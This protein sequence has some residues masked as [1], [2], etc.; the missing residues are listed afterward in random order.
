[1]IGVIRWA[2]RRNQREVVVIFP[3][4]GSIVWRSQDNSLSMFYYYFFR[5][6]CCIGTHSALHSQ[7]RNRHREAARKS[8]TKWLA[9]RHDGRC[10]SAIL[11]DVQSNKQGQNGSM[12]VQ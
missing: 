7:C 1:M 12:M 4:G 2:F 6:A 11:V 10:G 3:N 8:A 9:R 5:N